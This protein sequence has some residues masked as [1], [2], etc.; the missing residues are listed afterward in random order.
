MWHKVLDR[1]QFISSLYHEVP[2][3]IHVRIVGIKITDEGRRVSLHFN[4]PK[5][6]DNPPAKWRKSGYNAV[7]VELD[8][9]DIQELKVSY[10]K[11]N[12]M[13]NITLE[14]NEEDKFKVHISGAVNMDLVADIGIIQ[15]VSG[16]LDHLKGENT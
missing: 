6:A 3:L 14:K 8:F 16:Y 9:F 10:S 7:F 13:G 11:E 12:L 2:Q 5:F 4:M 1:N 15:T